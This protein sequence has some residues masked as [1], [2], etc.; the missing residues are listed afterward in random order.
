MEKVI[1]T[2]GKRTTA[3]VRKKRRGRRSCRDK[4]DTRHARRERK[5]NDGNKRGIKGLELNYPKRGKGEEV[6]EGKK[7][8]PYYEVGVGV[9]GKRILSQGR[10]CLL[11]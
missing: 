7:K 4:K 1:L 11:K 3:D 10:W 8:N 6:M 9:S 2:T 5:R